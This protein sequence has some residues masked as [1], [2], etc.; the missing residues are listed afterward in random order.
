MSRTP[1]S[2]RPK[3]PFSAING[4][5]SPVS[6]QLV[7]FTAD[8]VMKWAE[9]TTGLED[10]GRSGFVDRLESALQGLAEADLNAVG[11][12][13]CRYAL[14]WCATNRLRIVDLLKR[15]PEISQIAIEK[16][17][18][19][20][21]FY[22]TG[23]T[24][25]HSVL[26]ADPANR[27][28]RAWELAFPV[29]REHDPLGDV[30]WRKRRAGIV[31][32]L[33]QSVIPDQSVAHHITPDSYEECHFLL[34]NDMASITFQAALGAWSYGADMLEWDM[35]EPYALHK[36]Q[37]QILTAQ[38]ACERWALKCPWHLWNLKA[39]L[40]VYP[41]A[42]IIHTHRDVGRALGS[43]CSLC[44]RMN[45]KLQRSVDLHE[46]GNYWLDYSR[47]GLERGLAVRDALPASQVYDVR[48]RDLMAHPIDMLQD[49]YAHFELPFDDSL[50]DLFLQRIAEQPTGH[51]GEHDYELSEFGLSKE[52]IRDTFADYCERFGV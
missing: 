42:R 52:R 17:L 6:E 20:T 30:G 46:I 1:K 10:W 43:Q 24:F 8:G 23:T 22:R 34:Q 44:A 29:G 36:S 14:H 19:I 7:P 5:L 15:R 49:M 21:G 32:G 39:V 33:D 26:A 48:L 41:D 27:V 9:R 2:L 45:S 18:I 50:A 25:L 47:I 13:G 16:P 12:F 51:Q 40:A 38:R 35:R 28:G 4:L 37:L 3:F 31:F 11:R